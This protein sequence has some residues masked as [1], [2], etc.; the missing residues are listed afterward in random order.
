[1]RNPNQLR[2]NIELIDLHK[3]MEYLQ[4]RKNE[5]EKNCEVLQSEAEEMLIYGEDH[6]RRYLND[7]HYSYG[8][9]RGYED[10]I[11]DVKENYYQYF[12]PN[13]KDL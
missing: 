8:A 10:L 13:L 6:A 4:F 11:Q 5:W 2:D 9:V 12:F 3:L 1:M 7:I